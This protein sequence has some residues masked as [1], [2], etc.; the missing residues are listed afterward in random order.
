MFS[1]ASIRETATILAGTLISALLLVS[2]ATS[3]PLLAGPLAALI[4]LGTPLMAQSP[5]APAAAVQS[6]APAPPHC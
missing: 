2:A 3:L 1:T 6:P 5:P 4:A